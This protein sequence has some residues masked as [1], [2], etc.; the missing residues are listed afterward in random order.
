M[1]RRKAGR[2][3]RKTLIG[4]FAGVVVGAGLTAGIDAVRGQT[5]P[6]SGGTAVVPD[7]EGVYRSALSTLFEAGGEEFTDPELKAF[8]D[9]LTTNIMDSLDEEAEHGPVIPLEESPAGS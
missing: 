5:D 9:R 8:Y 4:I 2:T 1:M 3:V 7:M 6:G